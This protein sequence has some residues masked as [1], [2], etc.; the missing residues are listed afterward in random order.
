VRQLKQRVGRRSVL[1]IGL[2]HDHAFDLPPPA[3]R[4]P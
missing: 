1:P 3:P 2:G 4:R